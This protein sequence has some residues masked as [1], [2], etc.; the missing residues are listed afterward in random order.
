VYKW[1]EAASY[2]LHALGPNPDLSSKIDLTIELIEQVQMP[3]GYLNTFFQLNFPSM[4][5][6]NLHW[7]HEMYCAGH[8]L[9]AAVAHFEATGS[10]RLV[11][12]GEK[13]VEH[14]RSVFSPDSRPGYCGHQEFELGLL[15]FAEILESA[16]QKVYRDYAR[17]MIDIHGKQPS[18]FLPE[19]DAPEIRAVGHTKFLFFKD[20]KYNGEYAQDHTQL[21]YQTR[22]TGHAVRCMYFYSAATEAFAEQNDTE[23]ETALETIW[24]NLT[25]TQMYITG[26]IGQSGDNE[27]FSFDYDLPN[28]TAYAETCAAC[29]LIFWA[30]RMVQATG[31]A[32]YADVMECAIFNGML[33]GISEDGKSFFYDNPLESAGDKQRSGWFSCA[34]CPPNAARLIASVSQY[35]Y[36]Q[37][38]NGI[39]ILM[40]ISADIEWNGGRIRVESQFPWNYSLSISLQNA[41]GECCQ[42]MLRKPDYIS[43]AKLSCEG[44]ERDG[45]WI[46]TLDSQNPTATVSADMPCLWVQTDGRVLEN[47]GRVALQRGPFVYCCESIDI[48][49]SPQNVIVSTSE[50][51]SKNVSNGKV[52][53][54]GKGHEL[55]QSEAEQLYDEAQTVSLKPIDITWI[56][57]YSW[58]NRGP[59]K[60]QVWMRRDLSKL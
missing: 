18:I 22:A 39:Q 9:E 13:L 29:G 6:K 58:C 27:G 25:E 53:L 14:I 42:I 11:K 20:G 28:R 45:F 23:M 57:Y 30:R 17:W 44:V 43:N 32:S 47:T 10:E 4:R 40:P 38:D 19:F 35:S 33:S 5:W 56:P 2:L 26:G 16:K 34:C 37:N 3:D 1:I 7:A 8:L 36:L 21:R 41:S 12:V 24:R 48:G 55:A 52:T 49:T 51:I 50:N 54:H 31:K 60:M 46:F 59:T 15:R